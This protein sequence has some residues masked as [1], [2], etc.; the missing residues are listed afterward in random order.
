MTAAS[1]SPAALGEELADRVAL[2]S[3]E[4]LDAPFQRFG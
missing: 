2:T 3:G 4:R 1:F